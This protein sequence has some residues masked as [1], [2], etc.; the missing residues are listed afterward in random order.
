MSV[1]P[2][3]LEGVTQSELIAKNLNATHAAR[4]A[5]IQQESSEKIGRALRHQ[6]RTSGNIKYVTRDSAYIHNI[7]NRHI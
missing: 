1:K 7:Y 2:P 3:A 4:K 6:I 5:F